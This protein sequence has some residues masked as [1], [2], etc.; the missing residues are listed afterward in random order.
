M[1][2]SR[3]SREIEELVQAFIGTLTE[4]IEVATSARALVLSEEYLRSTAAPPRRTEPKVRVAAERPSPTEV[5]EPVVEELVELAARAREAL[6]NASG[7][8]SWFSAPSSLASARTSPRMYARQVA[9]ESRCPRSS[10][11]RGSG[12][13][14]H[15][16]ARAVG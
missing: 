7:V 9:R 4:A 10:P 13:R 5:Q 15:V 8:I 11:S 3:R 14:E 1:P 6:R 16:L 2:P 12:E